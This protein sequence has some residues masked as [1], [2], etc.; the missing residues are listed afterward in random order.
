[1][2]QLFRSPLNRTYA[3]AADAAAVALKEVID[4]SN[5]AGG[6]IETTAAQTITSYGTNQDNPEGKTF[7]A[8]QDE[9]GVAVPAMT[10]SGAAIRSLPSA[11]YN[12]RY[13]VLVDAS[14]GNVYL[15]QKS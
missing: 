3:L 14:G 7:V 6:S 9:D 5:M 12:Y 13:V 15:H 11:F 4:M 8:C 10:F 1:M 2:G